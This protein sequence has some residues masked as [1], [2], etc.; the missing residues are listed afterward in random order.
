MLKKDDRRLLVI[1]ESGEERH[2]ES[3]DIGPDPLDQ[4]RLGNSL[5]DFDPP[6]DVKGV[7]LRTAPVEVRPVTRRQVFV[8]G[9]PVGEPFE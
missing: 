4:S 1:S 3:I 8:D 6:T 9:R 5:A 2:I 7:D